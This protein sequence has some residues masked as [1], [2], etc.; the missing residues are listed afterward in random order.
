M[1]CVPNRCFAHDIA[2][3]SVYAECLAYADEAWIARSMNPRATTFVAIRQDGQVIS[4]LTLVASEGN[5]QPASAAEPMSWH[6][7]GVFTLPEARRKGVASAVMARAKR[8]AQDEAEA[9]NRGCVLVLAVL[10][11]NADAKILYE[12]LGFKVKTITETEIEMVFEP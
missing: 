6:V 3:T 4:S 1:F 9:R 10:A 8:F 2:F 7:N 11:A 5:N 12:K